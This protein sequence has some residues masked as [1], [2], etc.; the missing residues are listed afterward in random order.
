[1]PQLV[2]FVLWCCYIVISIVIITIIII[3]TIA[4]CGDDYV[5]L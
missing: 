1:M 5:V 4:D 2:L 3:G